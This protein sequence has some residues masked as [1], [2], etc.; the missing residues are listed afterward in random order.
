[1][2]KKTFEECWKIIENDHPRIQ[3]EE[4]IK[5]D[6]G[7][8]EQPVQ[9]QNVQQTKQTVKETSNITIDYDIETFQNELKGCKTVVEY[10]NRV[11]LYLI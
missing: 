2:S 6:S 8:V 3:I 9:K 1:M 10:V 4:L 11:N 7:V 5:M